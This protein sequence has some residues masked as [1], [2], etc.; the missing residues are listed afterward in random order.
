MLGDVRERSA[1]TR[2]IL[3]AAFCGLLLLANVA[4]TKLIAVG[5]VWAPGG[6]PLL[7]LV[8]DGGALLF[9]LTYIL[10]DVLA[11]IFGFR[12]ARRAIFLG[13]VLSLLASLSWWAVDLAPAADSWGN[14]A[15]WHSVLGFVPRIVAASLAG[16]LAGQLINARVLVWLRDR[17]RPGSLWARLLGSSVIGGAAD[18]ILF[19][20]IAYAGLVSGGTLANYTITGYLYK[21]AVEVLLLPLT[22]RFIRLVG[23]WTKPVTA[24]GQPTADSPPGQ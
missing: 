19:C 16:Y 5:P 4:A 15:A 2:E 12:A 8:F 6:V 1:A 21:L 11:E 10:G 20:T 18:T 7:P 17:A 3:V 13:F 23:R 14:Q 22:T 24:D 9:P